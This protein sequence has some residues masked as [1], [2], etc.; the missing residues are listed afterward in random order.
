VT[1]RDVLQPFDDVLLAIPEMR[2]LLDSQQVLDLGWLGEAWCE[3]LDVRRGEPDG[4]ALLARLVFQTN[5][6]L[7]IADLGLVELSVAGEG[8]G[9]ET[10]VR[11]RTGSR[12]GLVAELPLRL[13]IRQPLLRRVDP[14]S[15]ATLDE[16]L[17]VRARAFVGVDD[18][19]PVVT[20]HDVSIPPCMVAETG[21]IVALDNVTLSGLTDDVPTVLTARSAVLRWLPQFV[22]ALAEVPGF[23]VPLTD[24]VID[25]DGV[26]FVLDHH[27]PVHRSAGG[28]LSPRSAAF[29]SIA[30]VRAALGRVQAEVAGT[31]PVALEVDGHV[32]VPWLPG[33]ADIHVGWRDTP[34]GL[35]AVQV[36]LLHPGVTIPV[37]AG[38]V[39]LAQVEL[40]G[41]LDTDRFELAGS[42]RAT[43]ALPGW[44]AGPVRAEIRVSQDGERWTLRLAFRDVAVGPLGQL[45]DAELHLELVRREDDT[46]AADTAVLAAELAWRDL[47]SRVAAS[48]WPSA[49]PQPP[50]DARV[51]AEIAWRDPR[52]ELNVRVATDSTEDV[53][54]FLP[55]SWRPVTRRLE[56]ALM[57]SFAT[58]AEFAAA[59]A[60]PA[61]QVDVGFLVEFRPLL[62]TV[63]G[64]A[65]LLRFVMGDDAGFVTAR[66]QVVVGSG[67]DR[68]ELSLADVAAA[69]LSVP[70]LNSERSVAH[71]ELDQVRM[72]LTAADGG[73]P[74]RLALGA[75]GSLRLR[76][77]RVLG[78][79]PL[80]Q[81]VAAFL[82]PLGGSGLAGTVEMALETDGTETGTSFTLTGKLDEA[83]LDIDVLSLVGAMAPTQQPDESAAGFSGELPLDTNVRFTLDGL[84]LHVSP[85]ADGRPSSTSLEWSV[86]AEVA[87]A[88]VSAVIGI[89]TEELSLGL[90]AEIPL[91]LP[92]FPLRAEDLDVLASGAGRGWTEA[93]FEGAQ[94]QVETGLAALEP[95]GDASENQRREARRHR[96]ELRARG[97]MLAYLRG[98]WAPLNDA[99][100]ARFQMTAEPLIGALGAALALTHADSS[101]RLH[102]DQARVRVPWQRPQDITLE[103]G[104]TLRGFAPDDPFRGLEGLN[105]RLGL[106]PDQI[107]FSLEG[108]GDPVPLPDLGRYPNG[109]VSLSRLSLGYGFTRNSFAMAFA[110]A[111]TLPPQLIED[112]ELSDEVGFGVRLPSHSTLAFRLDVIPVPGPIPVVPVGEYALDLRTP[113]RPGIAS[114]AGCVPVWDGLQLHIPGLVCL[115]L[116]Q[117]AASPLFGVIPRPN[118]RFDG[119][120]ELGNAEN[121]LTV[122][123]DDL[124]WFPP[125]S[126]V[127]VPGLFDPYAPFFH[128]LC[129]NLRFLGLGLNIDLQRPFPE[130]SPMVL[131]DALALLADPT[132]PI[133]PDGALANLVRVAVRDASLTLPE[134]LQLLVPGSREALRHPVSAEIDLGTVITGAQWVVAAASAAVTTAEAALDAGRAALAAAADTPGSFD[135]APLIEL[136]PEPL[137]VV[138]VEFDFAGFGGRGAIA[139]FASSAGKLPTTSPFDRFSDADLRELPALPPDADGVLVAAELVVLEQTALSCVGYVADTGHF[140]LVSTA[141][142]RAGTL[143]VAGLDVPVSL[144]LR[145]RASLNG[146]I[147]RQRADAALTLRGAGRWEPIPGVIELRL[148]SPRQPV[149]LQLSTAGRFRL[150]GRADVSL[151]GDVATVSGTVSLSEAHAAVSG[152]LDF[153]FPR[154]GSTVPWMEVAAHGA[155][156]IGPGARFLFEGEGELRVLGRPVALAGVRLTESELAVT[157]SLDTTELPLGP[158]TVDVTAGVAGRAVVDGAGPRE[159]TLRGDGTVTVGAMSLS[160]RIGLSVERSRTRFSASGSMRWMGQNWLGAEAELSSDG[161]MRL[162][163][164]TAV[165]VSL[166]PSQLPAGIELARLFL[167]IGISGHVMLDVQHGLGEYALD[168]D[169]SVGVKMPGV[170]GQVFVLAMQRVHRQDNGSLNITLLN[171]SGL[172]T[173]PG[174]DIEIPVPTLTP[175]DFEDVNLMRIDVPVLDQVAF[176]ATDDMVEFVEDTVGDNLVSSGRLFSIPTA[177]TPG[178]EIVTLDDLNRALSFQLSLVWNRD[179]LALRVSRD[180]EEQFFQ[181]SDLA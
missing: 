37:G 119:D 172:T 116:K 171:I 61:L 40:S 140:A 125:G 107:Y 178:I 137:R 11:V 117:A 25:D 156:G 27:W 57:A 23:T 48:G 179:G 162:S 51:V 136:L 104:A 17:E 101:V 90:K 50:D 1:T 167:R 99:A 149:E 121:G 28:G 150:D 6:M 141:R 157:A 120:L 96:A 111:L 31:V 158:R 33:A 95:P 165:A 161:T 139:L 20:L 70:F 78:R 154:A 134:W 102:I 66:A 115:D 79:D 138:P 87:G 54:R 148:G 174:G 93:G 176:L 39:E 32:E 24:V 112:A 81:T 168:I 74:D 52:V 55:A 128:H 124:L 146:R 76:D 5:A 132:Q 47:A 63:P 8:G 97:A 92:R 83:Q 71:A 21:I 62:P 94:R 80:S 106:S 65:E 103:G 88:T 13:R 110:G 53:W 181:F 72:T 113:G 64:D 100:R 36:A 173:V 73:V 170:A 43:V 144:L 130:P 84:R 143:R 69:D 159:L 67:P 49:T 85:P 14:A 105:L 126:V 22:P 19:G 26:S 160:G 142:T 163:G 82:A 180:D 155:L 41:A 164:T 114:T 122:V 45:D 3:D 18:R 169:W 153:A 35:G 152:D 129:L 91:Q 29:G 10:V 77:P 147:T 127:V 145:G 89:S 68:I 58:G 118:M 166:L 59:A 151:F 133:D 7:T 44:D 9:I 98:L 109:S 34:E 38:R 86:T 16:G 75:T 135:A 60:T 46:W 12:R 123:C 42:L 15:G 4:R 175:D 2:A 177:F 131:F 30:G 108:S 56:L